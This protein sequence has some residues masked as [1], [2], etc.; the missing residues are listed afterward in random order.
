MVL[1]ARDVAM[2]IG[3]STNACIVTPAGFK[4]LSAE[5]HASVNFQVVSSRVMTESDSLSESPGRQTDVIVQVRHVRR[6]HD[7]LQVTFKPGSQEYSCEC[8]VRLTLAFMIQ[9]LMMVVMI[10]FNTNFL[11]RTCSTMVTSAVTCSAWLNIKEKAIPG[12][13]IL[14]FEEAAP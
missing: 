5:I 4:L 12:F 6:E 7:I 3:T 10:Y 2:Q 1:R 13:P 8:R 11:H 9:I 14:T